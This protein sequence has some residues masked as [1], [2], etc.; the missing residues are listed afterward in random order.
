MIATH[1]VSDIE[2]IAKDIIILKKG[3]I[4]DFNSP[5]ALLKEIDGTVWS[6]R[7]DEADIP[8][9]SETNRVVSIAKDD[10]GVS[11]RVL[12]EDRPAPD[13]VPVKPSLEDY[14]LTVFGETS[15]K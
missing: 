1:V 7:V 12:S 6:L 3:V 2:Y 11:I 14:Y 8:K 9:L 4:V 15:G 5:G 13:A 10:A